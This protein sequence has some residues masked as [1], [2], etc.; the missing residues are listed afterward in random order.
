MKTRYLMLTMLILLSSACQEDPEIGGTATEAL[1]GEW[2]IRLLDSDN[3]DLSGGYTSI[4]TY[5]SAAN[6]TDEIIF[7]D[8]GNI[9]EKAVRLKVPCNI[10]QLSFGSSAVIKNIWED[11]SEFIL[12]NGKIFLKSTQT[13]SGSI[14]DSIRFELTDVADGNTTYILCGYRRTGWK[15]DQH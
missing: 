5:N 11:E 8:Q 7:S 13:P 14:A 2:F 15:E 12:N 9:F 3:N 10:E 4:V 1:A 6:S